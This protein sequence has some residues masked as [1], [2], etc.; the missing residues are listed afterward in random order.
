MNRFIQSI[1]KQ[2][3]FNQGKNIFLD[4]L[5]IFQFAGETVTTVSKINSIDPDSKQYLIDYTTDKA[6]TEFCRVNQYYTFDLKAKSDLRCIYADLFENCR[7]RTNSIEDIS[8]EH[9]EK[10]KSWLKEHNSFGERIYKNNKE[11]VS[12][13]AC[14][15]YSPQLQIE[16]LQIDTKQILQPLL[17][18]GCGSKASLVNYLKDQGIEAFGIDRAKFQ[19]P[20]LI[21]AD[22]LEYEYGIEK[23]GTIVSNLGFS[24]H[25]NHHHLR[26]DGNY[27]AYGKTYM[28]ILRSLKTGGCFHYAPN[29]PFIEKYIDS[30]LFELKRYEINKCDFKTTIVKRI[31][32]I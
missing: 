25:F 2:I 20:F 28:N 19:S 10:L 32:P 22:W 12:P 17:D 18:I 27:I 7:T 26:E 4:N 11:K 15:E 29:L 23:W 14:S 31:N 1:D 21:T 16:V 9:Y 30:K 6:I 5:E 24:N 3:A 13:V 8:K